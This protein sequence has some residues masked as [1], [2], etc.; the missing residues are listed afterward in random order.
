MAI[1]RITRDDVQ[2]WVIELH[3]RGYEPE[4]IRGYYDLMAAI[5]RR[6]VEDALIPRSMCRAIEL[7]AVIAREKR[8]L[9]E[10]EVERLVEAVEARYRAARLHRRLPRPAVAGDRGPEQK[11]HRPPTRKARVGAR[12]DHDR[13]RQRAL[14]GSRVRQKQ[15]RAA[16]SRCPSSSERSCCGTSRRFRAMSGCFPRPREAFCLSLI[17][18]PS[19]RDRG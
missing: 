18:S 1:G 13:A 16:R 17:Q 15:R 19:P 8:Y 12:R 6:A 4:T 11:R 10:D 9:T 2:G 3:E 7:P 5:M 14:P